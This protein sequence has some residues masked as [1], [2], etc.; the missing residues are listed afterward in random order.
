[1]QMRAPKPGPDGVAVTYLR[2]S[3][4]AP[5]ALIQ[6]PKMGPREEASHFIGTCRPFDSRGHQGEKRHHTQNYV[7]T[8]S[9]SL[10]CLFGKVVTEST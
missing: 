10:H 1:M 6:T 2:A 7:T 5:G 9:E 4:P 8:F 3:S